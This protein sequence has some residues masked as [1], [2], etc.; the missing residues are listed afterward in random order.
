MKKV[1]IT[2]DT[3]GHD[4]AD[5]IL[6]LIWGATDQG[7]YGIDRIMDICDRYYAK[8]VF[9]VDIAEAWDYGKDKITEVITHIISRGH[10]VGVHIHPDHMADKKRL[11]L[12]EYTKEEQYEIIS[13][14]TELYFEVTG[15]RPI[16]FRA[17]KYGANNETL[18]ILDEL[19]YKFDFSQFYGQ[20]WCGINPPV[21]IMVPKKV[22]GLMEIPVTIFRSIRIG[23]KMR[24]DKL[25]AVMDSSEYK[26]IMMQISNDS[27]E[28]IVSLFYHSF[29]M[30]NWREHPDKPIFDRKEEKKF[31]NALEYVYNSKRYEFISLNTLK[32]I[33]GK[34][35]YKAQDD[36]ID[37]IIC[38]KGLI[39]SVWFT[40]KRANNIR[41]FNNKARWLIY[42]GIIFLTI[43]I[44]IPLFY[45]LI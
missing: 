42:G 12:W 6:R 4:G 45:W 32:S 39:R 7:L 17:G 41:K 24:Y 28:I 3:E 30:L 31:I 27:R 26:H 21:A 1:I 19:G 15:E 13:K 10:D 25:D 36:S 37:K 34:N 18:E 38:T 43:T 16:A 2:V 11:F 9:F 22:K 8:A 20:K 29:S 14:C 33:Y 44:A 35:D 5:P 40:L 23:K